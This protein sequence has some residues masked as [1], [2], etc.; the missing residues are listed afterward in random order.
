MYSIWCIWCKSNI[1]G[2]SRRAMFKQFM[3]QTN[4]DTGYQSK[5]LC[6]NYQG[7]NGISCAD[8]LLER[9]IAY[10]AS[11]APHQHLTWV[12]RDMILHRHGE[13]QSRLSHCAWLFRSNWHVPLRTD[14]SRI[15]WLVP[16]NCANM[17]GCLTIGLLHLSWRRG[18]CNTFLRSCSH[19]KRHW[20]VCVS[21]RMI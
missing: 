16:A 12:R 18:R 11:I 5:P 3:Y 1:Q 2:I 10:K 21:C 9:C 7:R 15:S 4:S 14:R 13:L 20:V 6:W 17:C 19:S 8:C